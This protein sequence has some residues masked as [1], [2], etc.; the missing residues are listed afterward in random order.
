MKEYLGDGVYAEIADDT[1]WL[2]LR[3][4]MLRL[5]AER[6]RRSG[7]VINEIFLDI[8]T[9]TALIEYVDR[10]VMKKSEAADKK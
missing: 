2:R 6:S 3:C 5:T 7:L 10:H 1:S 8:D 4:G 9:Y